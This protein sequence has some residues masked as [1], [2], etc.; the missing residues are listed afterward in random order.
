MIENCLRHKIIRDFLRNYTENRWKDLIPSLIQI[1]ILNLQKSFNKI[2]FTNEEIK[3]FLRHLQI[4]QI[5]N[6]KERNK[7]KEKENQELKDININK[8]INIKAEKENNDYIDNNFIKGKEND[9]ENKFFK[10]QKKPIESSKCNN[11]GDNEINNK[12]NINIDNNLQR[13]KIIDLISKNNQE[14]IRSCN[15]TINEMRNKIKNN[16]HYF[17]DCISTDLKSKLIKQKCDFYKKINIEQKNKNIKSKMDK[18]SYAISYDKDLRPESISKKINQNNN[19]NYLNTRTEYDIQNSNINYSSEKKYSTKNN[20]KSKNK[21]PKGIKGKYSNM[22][23]NNYNRIIYTQNIKRKHYNIGKQS[24]KND[25]VQAEGRDNNKHY[26]KINKNSNLN[27]NLLN[28]ETNNNYH[29]VKIDKILMNKIKTQNL[30]N[31]KTS[32]SYNSYYNR[33]LK[34]INTLYQKVNSYGIAL[35]NNNYFSNRD[36][37]DEFIKQNKINYSKLNIKNDI[38]IRKN[39]TKSERPADRK[40]NFMNIDD[41]SK[42]N[43]ICYNSEKNKNNEM[44]RITKTDSFNKI[45]LEEEDNKKEKLI[46]KY[47]TE[48]NFVKLSSDT[49]TPKN[50]NSRNN[51]ISITENKIDENINIDNILNEKKDK[52]KDKNKNKE[53]DENN[54]NKN[55]KGLKTIK[56]FDKRESNNNLKNNFE[57]A[58]G[59]NG[60]YRYFNVFGPEGDDISLTQF[61]KDCSGF[62]DSS[63]SNEIQLN[64]DCIFKESPLN[65]FKGNKSDKSN[66][67]N[68]DI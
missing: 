36:E 48:N 57:K 47:P 3:K 63:I 53:K 61:E 38:I 64:P 44:K 2:F 14:K 6:D 55:G 7:E 24:I 17:K 62:N 50:N 1:G 60:E 30:L 15:D 26:K 54:K 46:K 65:V 12:N 43:D 31:S 9:S 45:N 28:N 40:N 56:L 52:D 20:S 4:S 19:T 22:N 58:N 49:K 21:K 42:N 16:Y 10:Y 18:I 39:I 8:E 51:T 59:K 37:M 33:N 5:E 27:C 32:K 23:V 66:S 68:N 41:N 13:I 25:G 11:G 67:I 29:V 35:K 34:F